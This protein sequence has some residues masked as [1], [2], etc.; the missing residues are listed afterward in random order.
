[1]LPLAI[2]GFLAEEPLH[3]YQLKDRITGLTGHVKP[4]SDGALYPAI[5]RLEAKGLIERR[6][7]PGAGAAPRQVLALT[8][9]GRAELA[10]RLREPTPTEITDR[11]RYFTILAFLHRLEDPAAQA[12]VLRRRLDF[13]DAPGAGFFFDEDG[14]PVKSEDAPTLFRRGMT[15]IARATAKAEREWL[16]A[17]IAELEEGA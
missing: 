6:T 8:P 5:A 13:L 3:G 12:A 9:A 4:V 11:N 1:M 16:K 2:L 15:Q 10:R 14:K 17:A 7:E